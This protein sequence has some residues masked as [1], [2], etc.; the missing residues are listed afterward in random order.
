MRRDSLP[1]NLKVDVIDVGE[2][3]NG[4]RID[5]KSSWRPLMVVWLITAAVFLVI[6]GVLF[7]TN[8]S[9][10]GD[11]VRSGI[12]VGGLLIVLAA[13]GMIVF[14]GFYGFGRGRRYFFAISEYGVSQA[15]GHT[16]KTVS[17]SEVGQVWPVL[18]N[19]T[20][21]VRIVPVAGTKV[22][23]DT[24]RSL[25]DRLQRGLMERSI[26]LSPSALSIDPPLLLHLVRFYWQHPEAREEL[27]S[28]AVIDRMRRGELLG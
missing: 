13:L 12:N 14:L 8:L 1:R 5:V 9:G 23:V 2:H 25:I 16:V 24:G 27:K 6:R 20:H 28:D 26:D 3:V 18:V 7:F 19:N 17:W 22:H 11:S 15:L 4:L 21:V 10:D